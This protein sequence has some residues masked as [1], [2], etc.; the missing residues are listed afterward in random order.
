MIE[1]KSDY[2]KAISS[3]LDLT[4]ENIKLVY[5]LIC[6]KEIK[7]KHIRD[8][9][10][11]LKF[12]DYRENTSWTSMEIYFQLSA[13]FNCGYKVCQLAVLNRRKNKFK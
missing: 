6:D 12:D 8:K 7:L 5:S 11:S 3:T 1:N 10:I 13:D 2:I 4:D 9:A